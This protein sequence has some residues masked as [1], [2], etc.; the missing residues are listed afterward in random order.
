MTAERRRRRSDIHA[1][2]EDGDSP[3]TVP[4]K[5][6]VTGGFL[7]RCSRCRDES[8]S[9]LRSTG[10]YRRS[11]GLGDVDRRVDVP[12]EG[13]SARLTRP[14]SD[15]ERLRAVLDAAGR[16]HLR[17]RLEAA[18]PYEGA[19]VPGGLVLQHA[20]ARRPAR[21]VHGLR[22]TGAGESRHRQVLDGN[23][24]VLADGGHSGRSGP[25]RGA[26]GPARL[27]VR[28]GIAESRPR[29]VPVRADQRCPRRCCSRD[30]RGLRRWSGGRS[31]P[32]RPFG[33]WRRANCGRPFGPGRGWLCRSPYPGADSP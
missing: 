10:R 2:L 26:P 9:Y 23:R 12:I 15:A 8:R 30:R 21:V 27:Q 3:S 29:A 33:R 1:A 11:G 31:R 13:G 4:L 19:P 28:I 32:E 24:S 5:G 6:V 7:L 17:G 22:R 20:H 14:P 18:D 25:G 16:A